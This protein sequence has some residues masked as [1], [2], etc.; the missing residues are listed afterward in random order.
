V[1]FGSWLGGLKNEIGIRLRPNLIELKV[2]IRRVGGDPL[3]LLG[4]IIVLFF[5]SIGLLTPLLARPSHGVDPY[6]CP[7]DGPTM[8]EFKIYPPPSPP[9]PEHPFGTL[10]GF[11]IYYGC[12]WGTRTAFRVG[13]IVILIAL[14]LGLSIG[15]VAGYNG[16]LIDE[17]LM[18]FADIFF[19]F[20]GLLLAIV[21]V[22]ALP[23]VWPVTLGPISFAV[24]LS[25]LDK[26]V[27]ALALVGWPSYARVIRSEI[28]R[29]KQEDYVE[30]AKAIGCSGRRILVKHIL[31]NSMYPILTMAFLN[32]G[33]TVLFAATLSFLGFGP[34]T[35][36]ADWATIIS[37]SRNW[38]VT[39]PQDPFRFSFTWITPSMFIF[40]FILGWSL[41][42]DALRDIMDPTLRR[43]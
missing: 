26:L 32:F 4:A 41:L 38:I 29:V 13:S 22:V 3:S 7:Y 18:R 33:K 2:V 28:F 25:Q 1:G 10:Q 19:A 14:A 24:A 8:G 16:G 42:G 35:G 34:E 31:P 9:S 39:T 5:V 21:L 11:D 30:A 17:L 37:H 40:A 43:T 23:S 12:I 6:I 15:C 27:L 36:Y 20:P